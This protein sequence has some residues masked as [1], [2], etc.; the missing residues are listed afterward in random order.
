MLL[1][2]DG[3]GINWHTVV[4]PLNEVGPTMVFL[5]IFYVRTLAFC[6]LLVKLPTPKQ[7]NSP[8]PQVQ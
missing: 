3:P 7:S 8:E 6:T 5:F 4:T 1:T 2:C